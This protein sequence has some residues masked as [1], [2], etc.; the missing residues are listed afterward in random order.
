MIMPPSLPFLSSL[1]GSE[2]PFL[3]NLEIVNVLS[4]FFIFR[5]VLPFFNGLI[6]KR[7]FHKERQTGVFSEPTHLLYKHVTQKKID[8]INRDF[9]KKRQYHA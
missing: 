3:W 4:K 7:W 9:M 6:T 1:Y 5:I 8:I 2:N